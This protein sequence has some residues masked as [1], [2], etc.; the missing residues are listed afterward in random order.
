MN[1]AATMVAAI[2]FDMIPPLFTTP[3]E[4][5]QILKPVVTV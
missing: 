4:C 2:S 5:E 1:E 3:T